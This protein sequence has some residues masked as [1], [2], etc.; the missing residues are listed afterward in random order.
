MTKLCD[1]FTKVYLTE[2]IILTYTLKYDLVLQE[3]LYT[4]VS[5]FSKLMINISKLDGVTND[6]NS[7]SL[8]TESFKIQ[9]IVLSQFA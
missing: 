6:F 8:L 1:L 9:V 2:W 7:R 5:Q 4:L 3:K